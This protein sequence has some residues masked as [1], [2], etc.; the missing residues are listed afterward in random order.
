M[1]TQI[2]WRLPISPDTVSQDV[3]RQKRW[4]ADDGRIVSLTRNW[5]T[6]AVADW[7]MHQISEDVQAC[8]SELV[9]NVFEHVAGDPKH[10][11]TLLYRWPAGQVTL[12]VCD[13]DKRF[14][15][16][17]GHLAEFLGESGR[18]LFLVSA[19][20]DSLWWRSTATGKAIGCRFDLQRYG[21]AF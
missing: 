18:G 7:H 14:P 5:V 8:V 3:C 19:L 13:D 16:L 1:Q 11:E 6:A 10:F 21:L 9:T 17:N 2:A 12:V 4:V 15:V 20:S